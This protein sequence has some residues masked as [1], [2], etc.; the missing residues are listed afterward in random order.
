MQPSPRGRGWT[1]II[2]L[3]A[4]TFTKRT[5]MGNRTFPINNIPASMFACIS[6]PFQ[7]MVSAV[8]ECMLDS[9]NLN[10]ELV[11]L[12]QRS[13]PQVVSISNTAGAVNISRSVLLRQKLIHKFAG[14]Y[15]DLLDLLK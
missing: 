9:P 2:D 5:F 1:Y 8:P 3:D 4:D 14:N 12:Y 15:Y 11:T 13:E 10:L 7:L 6:D